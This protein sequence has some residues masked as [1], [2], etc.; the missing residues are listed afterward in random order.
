MQAIRGWDNH[1]GESAEDAPP[2]TAPPDPAA[3]AALPITAHGD[4]IM[5][6]LAGHPVVIVCGAT[7]SG[8]STQLPKLALAADRGPGCSGPGTGGRGRLI[9]HT[10]PRRIAARA[11]AARIAAETGTRVGGAVGYQ[12][13]FSDHTGPHTRIKLMTDGILLRELAADRNLSRYD[14]LII[15]EAHE[16]SLNIDL[17]LGSLKQ[18]VARRPELRVIV[19]SATIDTGKLAQFFDGAPII[20]VEG[21]SHPVEVRYRPLIAPRE[22]ADGPA[23]DAGGDAPPDPAED[24]AQLSLT[25]G[26]VA[27]VQEL[28]ADPA[29][30]GDILVFLPGEQSIR[31]A[32]EALGEAHLAGLEVLPL[33]ARLSARQQQRIFEPHGGRRVILATNVAE[34][35]LT[36]P[37][38]RH[39]IDS[40]LA[41][42]SRYSVRGRVQRLPLE[43]ISRASADQRRGRCGREA[44]GICIRLYSQQDFESREAFTPPEILRTHLASVL[45]QMAA[46]D[47]GSPEQFPF[48]DPP[49]TR[50]VNDG[51]RQ[52]QELGAMDEARRI[53]GLGRRIAALP[54]DPRLGRMLIAA[55]AHRCLAEMLVIT[56]FLA[57][58]DPR[59][60]PPQSRAA[61]D[62]R[63]AAHA[64]PRSDFVSVL[65]LWRAWRAQAATA[66]GAE[67]RRW[68]RAGLLS[69]LRMREWTDLHDQFAQAARDLGLE[70]AGTPAAYADLHRAILTGALAGIGSLEERREYR[71]SRGIRFVIAP[72]TPLASR[73]PRWVVAV[74][75]VET[76]RIYARMV[77]AV[78][79]AWIEAAGRHLLKREHSEPQWDARRGEVSAFESVSL[80]GLVLA[81]RRRI[82]YGSVAPAAAHAIFVGEALVAGASDLQEEFL[83]ANRALRADIELLEAKIRRRDILADEDTPAQ[84]YRARIPASIDGVAAFRRW[85]HTARQAQPRLLHMDRDL[86]MRRQAPEVTPEDFPDC[87]PAA[88]NVLPLRYVFDPGSAADGLTL[89]VPQP[90]LPGLDAEQLA[91]LVP[92]LRREKISALL[93]SL[94]K[95][96]RRQLVP[97]PEQARAALAALGTTAL[98]GFHDWLAR[99]IGSRTG[100]QLSAAQLA[101]AQLPDHLRL[102]LRVLRADGGV[103]AEGR[104]LAAL[105]RRARLAPAPAPAATPASREWD[106]GPLPQTARAGH[107][108]VSFTVYPALRD[109]GQGVRVVEARTAL[110]AETISR[111]GIAR[112]AALALPQQ[113]RLLNRRIAADREL[114]LLSQGLALS[115]PLPQTLTARI[116]AECFLPE[117]QALPRDAAAFAQRLELRADLDGCGTRL[118]SLTHAILTEWRAARTAV[119]ALPAAF[120][121]AAFEMGA[122]LAALL[123]PD[124]FAATPNPWLARLPRYLQ[125]VRR[126][127]AGLASNA[128]RDADLARRLGPFLDALAALQAEDDPALRPAVLE[129]RFLIEEFR[130]SLFAQELK[131]LVPV[132][133]Q[134]LQA[135]LDRIRGRRDQT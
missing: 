31:E 124:L 26:I 105:Q 57:A 98:P 133:A 61:A 32:A 24:A 22:Q 131:T 66:G 134:R 99:W 54:C 2:V 23:R 128:P 65:N 96:L 7:G 97:V 127:S 64:D 121:E 71:G 28:R 135:A 72:G 42:I 13:R 118:I 117:G 76:S 126:R 114:V 70:A 56:A 108:G 19:T 15:D 107:A 73:P 89:L 84:F 58:Q 21:R 14:T 38:V 95:E 80:H 11:L 39:V 8:K 37:C 112:L 122:Q 125:A 77:A 52:L 4:E 5:R 79:P 120:A 55:H 109:E 51:I 110:E 34:T 62:E 68:C 45:L 47:L 87:L 6:A 81:S 104:D 85:W 74:Q 44:P 9:G 132:S 78:Q 88:G 94:P 69:F 91:W 113:V 3:P 12:V 40:G 43:R 60:R 75:L 46:A 82:R 20:N 49:D 116:F 86:L 16:R 101:Q 48:P 63:H 50:L 115:Q 53:T 100:A 59:E 83:D 29:G 1:Q 123:P 17:L 111:G 119:D 90:L 93:R 41:R 25:E 33:Y 129:L 10:Q 103:I 27:A 30:A 106:F 35:S 67:L 102:N 36:V 130:V 92:G 18:L